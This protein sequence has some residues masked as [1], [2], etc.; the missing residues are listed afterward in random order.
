MKA[1][2]HV[3]PCSPERARSDL[4]SENYTFRY[5]NADGSVNGYKTMNCRG[6]EAAKSTAA[7]W[8][9]KNAASLEIWYGDKLI[10]ELG[11]IQP[12]HS[13]RKEDFLDHKMSSIP[14]G[15]Y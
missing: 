11:S 3:G 9:P 7:R 10:C 12:E 13:D 8:M 14:P 2:E 5:L 15:E 4:M 1:R 6:H